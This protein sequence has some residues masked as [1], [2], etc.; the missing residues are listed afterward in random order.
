MDSGS[1]DATPAVAQAAGARVYAAVEV[2]PEAG[3]NPYGGK[4]ESLWKCLA[5][6]H[7]DL[8]VYLDSDTQNFELGFVTGL[9][10]PLLTFAEIDFVKAFYERPL[11]G[12]ETSLPG[13]GARVTELSVRP[14]IN[15]FW[16]QLAGFV[17]PLSGEYAGRRDLLRSV[18]F[19]TGYAVD[20]GL[21]ID[22]VVA[23]G[24]DAVA[25]ANLGRRIHRNRDVS[26]LGRM[27]FEIM[28]SLF[29]R[30]DDDARVKLSEN[31]EESLIQFENGADGPRPIDHRIAAMTRPPM[32][33]Y[34]SL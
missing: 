33:T 7:G 11:I 15:L 4:G 16:Q 1:S 31:L 3:S 22:I 30:L 2:L 13:G 10:A 26:A 24:L 20:I 12:D 5:V 6:A 28:Y 19:P 29:T 14:L 21:L 25:Q 27:A 34:L 18:P 23:R 8:V 32:V 9:V 17:Q